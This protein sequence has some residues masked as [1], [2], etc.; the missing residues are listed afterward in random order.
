MLRAWRVFMAGVRHGQAAPT[1]L[2]AADEAEL[3]SYLGVT[4]RDIAKWLAQY[5]EDWRRH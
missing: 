4:P 2:T 5:K 3:L 1:R